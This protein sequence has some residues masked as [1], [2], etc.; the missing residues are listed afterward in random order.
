MGGT[1]AATPQPSPLCHRATFEDAGE[2]GRGGG[3]RDPLGSG[4]FG[5]FGPL[6]HVPPEEV[7]P[8]F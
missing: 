2:K 4:G 1:L 5:V 6:M 3:L 7:R 8:P